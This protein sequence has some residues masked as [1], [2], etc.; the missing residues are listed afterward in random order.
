MEPLILVTGA[1]F[2]AGAMNA[3]AGGG[4]FVSLPAMIAAGLPP[5][6]ANASSTVA[7]FPGG[8]VSAW[9][10]RDGLGPVGSVPI[11]KMLV[12]TLVGGFVGAAL[13]LSTSSK[14]FSFVLPWLLLCASF[15][16][17]F[18]RKLGEALRRRWRIGAGAVLSIQFALG[19]Y[20]GYFGGAVGIMMMAVWGL[21]D[22][23]DLKSLNAPRTLLVS[24]A[25][26]VAVLTFA[27][28]QA[29]RWPE[30]IA[31]LVAAIAG[32]YGGAQIGRRAPPQ[33]IRAGT[34][35]VSA[36]ITVAFFVKTYG[37]MLSHR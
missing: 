37:P 19:V 10:Y 35:V 23:R 20:G 6:Q 14:T 7:L 3:L 9:A 33:W 34:L 15:T 4:S 2:L 16:L 8:V 29:V 28:A 26:S 32:G 30:T 27:A 22:A 21:L 24:A 5:V 31:M 12:T 36:G 17:A 11:R 1:G 25:N 18:G 13:L